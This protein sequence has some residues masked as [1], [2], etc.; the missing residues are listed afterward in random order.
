MSAFAKRN[1]FQFGVGFF[2]VCNRRYEARVQAAY[3][4]GVFQSGTHRVP[5][6]T[7]GVADDNTADIFTKGRFK[8]IRFGAGGTAAG[9]RIGFVRD[10]YQLFGNIGAVQAVFLFRVGY[11]AVHYLG[12]VAHVQAGYVETA[13]SDFGGQEFSQ[14]FHTAFGYFGF[15]F[16]NQGD[17]THT[18]NHTVA[19]AVKRQGSL[20][21]IGFRGSGAGGQ[22]GRQNPLGH[23]IIGNVVGADNDNA[24]AAAEFNPVLRHGNSLGGGS[25]SGA[26]SRRRTAG[27]NPLAEVAMGNDNSL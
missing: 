21:N 26:H 12:N 9:R 7:L 25:A 22:E 2:K 3:G 4:D 8:R 27:A 5:G 17:R 10:K 14:R 18:H 1:A 20:G 16:H 13:V 6:E 23:I 11:Q 24:F 19:A 15:V